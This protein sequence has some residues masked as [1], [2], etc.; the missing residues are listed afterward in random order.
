MTVPWIGLSHARTPT[1][2]IA[3]VT[4]VVN[5]LRL[6]SWRSRREML[7]TAEGI[8]KDDTRQRGQDRSFIEATVPD[9]GEF[10]VLAV[11]GAPTLR[12][13]RRD[14]ALLAQRFF[15]GEHHGPY[16]GAAE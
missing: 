2:D 5:K 14:V 9:R 13:G 10:Q 6:A 15:L 8:I 16:H 7:L 11:N 1:V 4:V 3:A 12:A